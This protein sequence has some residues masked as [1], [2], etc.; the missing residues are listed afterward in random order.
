MTGDA[1]WDDDDDGP[2]LGVPGDDDAASAL[3]AI[4][5]ISP[6]VDEGDDGLLAA[7][8]TVTNPTGTVSATAA[9][10]VACTG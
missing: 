6:I 5:V 4:D 1:P 8:F 2:E 7:L 10:V 3:D 9:I